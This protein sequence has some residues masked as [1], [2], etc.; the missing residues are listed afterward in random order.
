VGAPFLLSYF[1]HYNVAIRGDSPTALGLQTL[2]SVQPPAGPPAVF[3][4]LGSHIIPL[5]F[6]ET[7]NT[8]PCDPSIQE[9]STPCDDRWTFEPVTST[10]TAGGVTWHFAV[11][12]WRTSTGGFN[13]SFSSEEEHVTQRDIYGQITV[14]TNPTTS[15]LTVDGTVPA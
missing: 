5:N 1:A 10:T 8:P 2:L 6:L 14:D 13:R 11:L 15:T 12:G 3:R 7:D 9:S 4:M